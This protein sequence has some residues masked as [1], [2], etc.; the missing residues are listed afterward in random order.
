MKILHVIQTLSS[1]YG[2][3]V[4]LLKALARQQ[5]LSGDEVTICTTNA[6]YPTGLL[7]VP[8]DKPVY[9]NGVFIWYHPV[10]SQPLLISYPFSRWIRSSI[11]K[12]DVVH[13]QGLYRFPVTYAAWVARKSGVPYVITPQGSLDPFLYKQSRYSVLL[14]RLYERL[15]DFPNINGASVINYTAQHE[16]ERAKYLKFTAPTA[17]VPN[18]IDWH[19]Y[20]KLPAMGSF[21]KSIG[22]DMDT[23]LALFLGRINFKKGIDLLAPGFSIVN[24]FLPNARLAVVGPDNEGRVPNLRQEF[25][26][27]GIESNV[28]IVDHLNAEQVRQAYVD[29]DV[30]LL[31]SYTENF[32]MTVV[33][34]MACGCPVV[35]SDQVNI[36]P[37]IE[38]S[39][40]GIVVPLSPLKIAQ[41]L[42]TILN[43][44]N[45]AR[46]M[47]MAGRKLG[48]NR[49]A[50]DKI[51]EKIAQMYKTIT[52]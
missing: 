12:F 6:D 15:F 19:L 43:D 33:E 7:K 4:T 5:V 36:W 29:A 27:K 2:G 32:G 18:G 20:D 1:R 40:A 45:L 28:H 13:I 26:K 44:R 39:G 47:G 52:A 35:I 41:A 42:L 8:T 14:K 21:R 50:Y 10:Q 22:L 24:K 51:V 23:P 3:P 31:P 11:E 37:D 49:F 25:Q 38:C 30:F 46:R 16:L 9:D 34:A 17:I 48:Q